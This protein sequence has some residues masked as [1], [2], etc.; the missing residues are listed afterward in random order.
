MFY[1]FVSLD[2]MGHES[3]ELEIIRKSMNWCSAIKDILRF[4]NDQQK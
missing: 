1:I 3:R 2:N 4:E